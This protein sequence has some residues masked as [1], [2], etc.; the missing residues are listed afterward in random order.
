MGDRRVAAPLCT[1]TSCHQ[2][3]SHPEHLTPRGSGSWGGK[4]R[5]GRERG[6]WRQETKIDERDREIGTKK[7]TEQKQKEK[8][9]TERKRGREMHKTINN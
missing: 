7:D 8:Y 2:D 4:A 5:E 6:R 9:R 3:R 1:A